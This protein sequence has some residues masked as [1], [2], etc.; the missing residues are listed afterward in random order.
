MRIYSSCFMFFIFSC[1]HVSIYL[2]FSCYLCF[3]AI[4]VLMVLMYL[5]IYI[6]IFIFIFSCYPCSHVF[7]LFIPPYSHGPY[8]SYIRTLIIDTFLLFNNLR[9][10]CVSE[11]LGIKY[12]YFIKLQYPNV[13]SDSKCSCGTLESRKSKYLYFSGILIF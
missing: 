4:H 12:F 11:D 5:Y 13:H 1:S 3:H 2:Y 7:M 8:Y 10:L 6:Y 9:S